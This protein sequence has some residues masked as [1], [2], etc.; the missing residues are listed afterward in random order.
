MNELAEIITVKCRFSNG[1][2]SYKNNSFL[3]FITLFL[4]IKKCTSVLKQK[5]RKYRRIWVKIQLS[6]TNFC[7]TANFTILFRYDIDVIC[8]RSYIKHDHEIHPFFDIVTI[9]YN[10]FPILSSDFFVYLEKFCNSMQYV[11]IP[12]DIFSKRDDSIGLLYH[13]IFF[14]V[15]DIFIYL[16]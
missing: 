10:Y 15:N 9:S 11:Q 14:I 7:Q 2:Y 4:Q 16:L 1:L 13:E 6:H 5:C 12:F 3:H 8:I